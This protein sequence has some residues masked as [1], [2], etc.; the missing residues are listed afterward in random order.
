MRRSWNTEI[1]RFGEKVER[2]WAPFIARKSNTNS[3]PPSPLVA[4]P[5]LLRAI[6]SAPHLDNLLK[7]NEKLFDFLSWHNKSSWNLAKRTRKRDDDVRLAQELARRTP[8]MTIPLFIH[9][10]APYHAW[11]TD[12]EYVHKFLR[13]GRG[14]HGSTG[15]NSSSSNRTRRTPLPVA[16]RHAVWNAWMGGAAVG[17]GPCH[18]CSRV[19]TQQDFECGHVVPVARGGSNTISNLRPICRSCNRSMGVMVLTAFQERHFPT[20]SGVDGDMDVDDDGDDDD[21]GSSKNSVDH[22]DD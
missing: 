11:V 16:V 12:P 13:N 10:D 3:Q 19:I 14:N 8:K 6:R 5:P 17:A 4:L 1:K 15:S 7:T 2:E 21:K 9:L 18:V 20:N 22:D